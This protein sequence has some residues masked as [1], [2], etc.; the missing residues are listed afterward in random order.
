MKRHDGNKKREKRFNS[1]EYI[2][3]NHVIV[4]WSY[5]IQAHKK[6]MNNSFRENWLEGNHSLLE[7]KIASALNFCNRMKAIGAYQLS[8]NI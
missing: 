3:A 6:C 4:D 1:T 7:Y 2:I 5:I 8:S